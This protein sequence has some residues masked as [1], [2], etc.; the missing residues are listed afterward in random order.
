MADRP[1]ESLKPFF[2]PRRIAVVGASRQQGSIGQ[3]LLESLRSGGFTGSIIP[4]NPQA[5]TIAGLR[6][7]PSLSAISD[8]IDLVIL[9]VPAHLVLPVIDE[10]A[11]KQ[12]PAAIIIAAGFAETG[13]AGAKIETELRAKAH[14]YGIRLVGPNC[15]GVMNLDPAIRLN[16]TYTP[17][18]PPPGPISIASESG[19]VGTALVM[20]AE[21]MNLGVSKYVSVGNHVDVSVNDLLHYWEEDEQTGVILLYLETITDP[22][23]FRQ[24]TER[25][26]RRKPIIALK[27]G[28][29]TAGQS[30]A[31]SHTAAL[32]TNDTAV[33]ALFAQCGVIRATAFEEW[34]ALAASFS[35]RHRPP[36]RRTGIVTN[37]GGAGVLCA[38]SCAKEGLLVSELRQ[39]TRFRLASF[40]PPMAALKNPVDVIGI[41]TEDQHAAAVETL[42]MSDELDVL[43]IVHMSVNRT[44]ND[45][46]AAG[47]IRGIHAARQIGCHKPVYLCWMAEGDL[48]RRFT[49]DGEA[50]P[51]YRYPETPARVISRVLSYETWRRQSRGVASIPPSLDLSKAK[52]ICAKALANRG[53]G[54]LR[55]EEIQSLL[56]AMNI[57][58]VGHLAT[59]V[60]EAI[61]LAD[62]IGYPVAVKLASH[63]VLHKTELGAVFLNLSSGQAVKQA[64]ETIDQK[65][66][67]AGKLDAREGMLV[68]PMVSGGVEVVVGVTRDS[69]FGPL[70]A[71][72]LGGIHVEILGDVQFGLAPLTDQDIARMIRNIKGY[73]LLTGYRG[74]PTVDVH[75][76]EDVLIRISRLV[77]AIPEIAELDFNPIIALPEGQG[78]KIVDAKV[79]VG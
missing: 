76:I 55:T 52:T 18:L 43:I 13:E 49:V 50:I 39:S 6:A 35:N 22:H 31:G 44:D 58:P 26:G 48:D 59:T 65:L 11:A 63:Q 2:Y 27:A 4:V 51:T 5:E 29:T 60:E 16:A 40:L 32:A 3:R 72:G 15:F 69:S 41:A 78:C 24:L 57:P 14:R 75:A 36:G 42:L 67:Q 17:T 70:I 74:R 79:L 20:A 77:E 73:P 56:A 38:D 30:A 53:R 8:P 54:W 7:F 25:V 12:V 46:A 45:R 33:E 23:R 21:R 62:T 28:R 61:A 1:L 68:Q 64:F 71:F 9:T 66:A 19:G 10:C 37:S 47:I 34:L